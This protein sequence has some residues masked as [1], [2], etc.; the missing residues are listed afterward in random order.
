MNGE[1]GVNEIAKQAGAEWG[2]DYAFAPSYVPK[3]L[4]W[5]MSSNNGYWL[6]F[7]LPDGKKRFLHESPDGAILARDWYKCGLRELCAEKKRRQNND[8]DMH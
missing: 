6:G 8:S 5:H 2:M 3:G 7:L 1:Y 4:A